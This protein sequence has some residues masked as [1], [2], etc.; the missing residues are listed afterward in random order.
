MWKPGWTRALACE[1]EA[2]IGEA[3]PNER[4]VFSLWGWSTLHALGES[5][6]FVAWVVVVVVVVWLGHTQ[7]GMGS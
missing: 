4:C 6:M 5:R 3:K 2:E 1:F 7:L